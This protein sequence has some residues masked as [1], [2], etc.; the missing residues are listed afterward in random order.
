MGYSI[1]AKAKNKGQAIRFNCLECMGGHDGYTDQRG[2][3]VESYRPHSLVNACTSTQ[4][5]LWLYRFGSDPAIAARKAEK[6][7]QVNEAATLG[8]IKGITP[9]NEER[10]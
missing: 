3:K 2:N 9:R 4:C 6:A 5:H 7:A 8:E 10:S 1:K